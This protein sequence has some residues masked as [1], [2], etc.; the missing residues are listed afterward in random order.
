MGCSDLVKEENGVSST[1]NHFVQGLGGWWG[2]GVPKGQRTGR[3]WRG[4]PLTPASMEG[5]DLMNLEGS[6]L[7]IRK[8]CFNGGFLY[9]AGVGLHDLKGP[10]QPWLLVEL[11]RAS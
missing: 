4:S 3:M 10:C 5:V 11:A 8:R 9:W 1:E 2:G 6:E 7:D